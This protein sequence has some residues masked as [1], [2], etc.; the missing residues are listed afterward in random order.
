MTMT[1]TMVTRNPE[2]MQWSIGDVVVWKNVFTRGDYSSSLSAAAA[3]LR[4]V[5]PFSRLLRFLVGSAVSSASLRRFSPAR[6]IS[7]R[8]LNQI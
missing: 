4:A 3:F 1:M 8:Y 7:V 2:M 5:M 6:R